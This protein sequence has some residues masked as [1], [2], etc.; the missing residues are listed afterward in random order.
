M[1]GAVWTV[2][3]RLVF[4]VRCRSIFEEGS[5]PSPLMS[6]RLDGLEDVAITGTDMR[7]ALIMRGEGAGRS[8][9][10]WFGAAAGTSCAMPAEG[11]RPSSI[12]SCSFSIVSLL[13][14]CTITCDYETEVLVRHSSLAHWSAFGFGFACIGDESLPR[15][16]CFWR[17]LPQTA[18]FLPREEEN[19]S[20]GCYRFL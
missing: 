18:T 5:A 19:Q 17:R 8:G 15:R 6:R 20:N 10:F 3:W 1:K 16:S 13:L 11:G 2:V 9:W 7:L 4:V 12:S 14:F